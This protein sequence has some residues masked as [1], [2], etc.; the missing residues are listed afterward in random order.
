MNESVSRTGTILKYRGY[1]AI[2]QYSAQDRCFQGKLLGIR[3]CIQF[4]GQDV[5]E[6][7][8][9]FKDSIE[10]YL[11]QCLSEG[12]EPQKSFSGK[13]NLRMPAELHMLTA[14]AA[15]RQDKKV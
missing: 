14:Q 15:T 9:A 7:E 8:E 4:E 13:F 5:E 2:P 12:I 1:C 6:L 11:G 3:D 10:E